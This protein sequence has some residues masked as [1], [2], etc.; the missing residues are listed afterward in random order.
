MTPDQSYKIAHYDQ[1]VKERSGVMAANIDLA[2]QLSE[3]QERCRL[4]ESRTPP[5][6][7]ALVT[8]AVCGAL[9]GMM[10]T[11]LLLHMAGQI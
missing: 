7:V 5:E 9:A 10:G 4:A 11:L 8:M 1:M 2:D 3:S 6:E